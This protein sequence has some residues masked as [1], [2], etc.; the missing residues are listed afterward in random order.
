MADVD[1][2]LDSAQQLPDCDEKV[3][4]L[5][6]AVRIFDS[7]GDEEEGYNT[8]MQLVEAATWS[9][10]S[11]RALVAF[12]WCLTRLDRMDDLSR[13]QRQPGIL[14][15]FKWILN[16]ATDFPSIQRNRIHGLEADFARRVEEA[17]Y[18]LRPAHYLSCFNA[19]WM[20]D[21][22]RA[23]SLFKAWQVAPRDTMADC[24]ACEQ[25]KESNYHSKTGDDESGERMMRSL[26]FGDG[27]R[28]RS[29]PESTLGY[30]TE[31]LLRQDRVEEAA[32]IHKRALGS[33]AGD[34]NHLDGIASQVLYLLRTEDHAAAIRQIQRHLDFAWASRNEA[35][36]NAFFTASGLALEAIA[37]KP[38]RRR[39]LRLPT[40]HPLARED[41]T[42]DAQQLADW[43]HDAAAQIRTAFNA[44]NGNDLFTKHFHDSRK[45]AGM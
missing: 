5:E 29:V 22:D 34:P 32:E 36:R 33:I 31:L 12:S 6:E 10:H 40:D 17:G 42:Y 45:M 20:G 19:L 25:S 15:Y 44:R 35:D 37:A 13:Q 2:L 7:R 16:A 21:L 24:L 8:R 11:E 4:I 38:K 23:G 41:N 39:K 18:S 14:W 43:L 26:I 1:Q 27:P 28:C 30:Y 3:A 9:G